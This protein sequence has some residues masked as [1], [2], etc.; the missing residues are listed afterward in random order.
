MR[1]EPHEDGLS[2]N[3]VPQISI[4]I[5]EDKSIGEQPEENIWVYKATGKDGGFNLNKEKK[6]FMEVKKRFLEEFIGV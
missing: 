1:S 4:T 3:K 5:R 6:T 2:G